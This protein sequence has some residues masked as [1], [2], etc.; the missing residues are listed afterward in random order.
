MA[1]NKELIKEI[2]GFDADAKTDGLNNAQ[3]VKMLKE[4][5]SNT[6]E[7]AEAGAAAKAEAEAEKA[8]KVKAAKPPFSVGKGKALTTKRG[9]LGGGEEVTAEDLPGGKDALTALVESGHVVK[10]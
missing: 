3:L 1:S 9:I 6:T 5:K 2:N 8:K 7:G 4:L 10:A